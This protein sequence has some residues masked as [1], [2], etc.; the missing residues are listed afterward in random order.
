MFVANVG[1]PD[2]I[3]RLVVGLLLILSPFL[4]GAALAPWLV[5]LLPIVGVVLA[6]TA[7]LG[8]CPIYRV[9]GLS[10]RGRNKA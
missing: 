10:T 1:T 6:A 3:A 4:F 9:F 8:F 2:R 7:F 5:W